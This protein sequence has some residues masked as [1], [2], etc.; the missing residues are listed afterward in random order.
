MR[1]FVDAPHIFFGF[2]ILA[3]GALFLTGQTTVVNS[4]LLFVV[5]IAAAVWVWC[6]DNGYCGRWGP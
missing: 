5:G 3:G 4:V 1:E 2:V 6:D